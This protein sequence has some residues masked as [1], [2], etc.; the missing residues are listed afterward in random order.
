MLIALVMETVRISQVLMNLYQTT[1]RNIPQ[2]FFSIHSYTKKNSHF[3]QIC[4]FVSISRR[5]IKAKYV[6]IYYYYYYYYYYYLQ[7]LIVQDGPLASLFG[8][9]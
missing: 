1:R 5:N 4:N 8:V 6:Y 2:E 7:A 3:Y 9:S